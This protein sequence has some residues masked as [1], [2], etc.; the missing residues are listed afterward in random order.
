MND[1]SL[2]LC[3]ALIAASIPGTA[4][5]QSA[6]PASPAT[7]PHPPPT[8]VSAPPSSGLP[9]QPIDARTAVRRALTANPSL[10]AAYLGVAQAGQDVLAEE[11][12]YPYVFQADV[13]HTR[14]ASPRLLPNDDVTTSTSRS[15]T[16]GTALRRTFPFGTTAEVRLEGERFEN[17]VGLTGFGDGYGATARATV[18]HPLLR[19]AGTK[20]GE[21]GLRAAQQSRSGANHTRRRAVSELTR[22]VLFAYW[23]LWYSDESVRIEQAAIE[24]ARAQEIQAEEQQSHGALAPADVFVFQTRV[25]S[26]EETMAATLVQ[27]EQ[28][29]LE[30]NRLMGVTPTSAPE[31]FASET[32]IPGDSPS[33]RDVEVALRTGSVELAELEAQVKLARIRAE[34]AGEASRARLDLEG[35]VQ[36]YGESQKPLVAARRAGEL[37]WLTVHVGA[38][39]ELPL[40]SSRRTAEKQSALIGVRIAEQNLKAARDGLAADA[41]L[42]VRQ[43]RAAEERVSLAARTVAVA[44]KAHEAARARFEL[45]GGIALQVQQAEE[46]LRR[47]RLSLARMRVELVQ[48]QVAMLHLTGAF[49][50]NG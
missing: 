40:D 15:Y 37:E 19:G 20:V 30:L 32:P 42:I 48:A 36:T 1:S 43:A 13:G 45:G 16:V 6:S 41:V 12:R 3:L 26:L 21:A 5:A 27:R 24:L 23:E 22:D 2:G 46:E 14:G 35:F 47:A 10:A 11:G 31:L 8:A 38:V 33:V 9:A 28:R 29:S 39:F 49:A 7:T 50:P 4:L 44:E 25:A 18:T 34:T 17:D